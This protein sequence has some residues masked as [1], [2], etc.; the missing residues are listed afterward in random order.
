MSEFPDSLRALMTAADEA[1]AKYY[2]AQLNRKQSDVDQAIV[3]DLTIRCLQKQYATAKA[4]YD[5]AAEEYL[6]GAG[7][8]K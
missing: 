3:A 2:A 4:L 8:M 1:W 6:A 5:E 7:V